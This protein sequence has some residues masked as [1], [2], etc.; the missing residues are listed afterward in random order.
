MTDEE[1]ALMDLDI[2]HNALDEIDEASAEVDA[3]V[4]EYRKKDSIP[5]VGWLYSMRAYRRYRQSYKEYVALY[6]TNMQ[7]VRECLHS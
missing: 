3:R 7:I 2:A 4:N 5:V 6:N 1:I